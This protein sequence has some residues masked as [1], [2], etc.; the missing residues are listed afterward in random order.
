VLSGKSQQLFDIGDLMLIRLLSKR[1]ME[2]NL[3]DCLFL[4]LVCLDSFYFIDFH[5]NASIARMLHL[6]FRFAENLVVGHK[7]CL[8]FE[9]FGGFLVSYMI[10]YVLPLGNI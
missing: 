5:W 8:S 10:I 6:I 2:K 4:C 1:L 7:T 3:W 9:F